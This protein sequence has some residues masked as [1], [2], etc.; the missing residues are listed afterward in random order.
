VA[1]AA[2]VTALIAGGGVANAAAAGRCGPHP[3]CATSLTPDARA[4]LL[5]RQLTRDEKITLLTGGAV[6]RLD[7]PPVKFT[8][9]GVGAGGLGAGFGRATAM[10]AG[11][12]LAAGFDSKMALAYGSLVGDEVKLRGFDGDYGPT[13]NIM[14]T[15]LGGRTFEAYGEDPFLASRMAVGWIQGAQ[16]Q[17]IIADVKH[18]AANNQEGQGGV[19]PGQGAVGGR[20]LINANVD[21]RTLREIYFPAFEAAIK[22]AHAGTVMCSYNRLNGT[23]ACEN[24]HLLL[25][26]LKHDWGFRGFVVSDAGAAHNT[27]ENLNN[28][29]DFDIASTGYSAPQVNLALATGQASEATLDGHVR[30]I[31]RTLFAFGFFDRPAYKDD[32]TRIDRKGHARL[33]QRV[34]E[35]AITLLQ[36]KAILPLDAR[37]LRSIA[38][39]GSAADRYVRGSG[40][41][42]VSTFYFVTAREGITRR[43]GPGVK[44]T[45]DDGSNPASA[46]SVARAADVAIVVAADSESEGTDKACMSLSCPSIGLPDIADG[47]NPQVSTGDTDLQISQVAAAQPKTIV[48]LETGAPVLTAWR[49]QVKGLLAAWYPGEE[50]GNAIARVL[51]GDVDPGGRLPATFPRQDADIPTAGDP[52]KYPGVADNETYKEGVLVGYRWYDANGI[53]PAFPFG[54]GL[55]YAKFAYRH[56]TVRAARPGVLGATIGVD[57]T[58]TGARAGTAVP[59]LYL[60]LPRPAPGVVQPPKQLKGFR[61][62]QLRRGERKHVSFNILAR[63][64]SY[65]DVKTRG[66]RVARGCYRVMLGSSSRAIVDTATLAVRGASC[67][68]AAA[69]TPAVRVKPKG[70]RGTSRCK[71]SSG[72]SGRGAG[73]GRGG[74]RKP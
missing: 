73:G 55:S 57:V 21:E 2:V 15:P 33:A 22:E 19:P 45:Y 43:A 6:Q 16:S 9:G 60:G 34:E 40:S 65:W 70:R 67:P 35:Q 18:Y 28:G 63:D 72:R 20:F 50:G 51:F 4:A 47:Q 7:V 42:E 29:L 74:C 62:L 41:S 48:V 71:G 69:R 11:I 66:W 3:W 53:A 37:R 64:L 46:A 36:N 12:A 17:G 52:E 26:V 68:G 10:P 31:L 39:I 59:Q 49:N 27:A 14:R 24:R 25:E 54:F 32:V 44:V 58:N 61:K 8:D 30:R 56:L 5:L 23:Y 13:V 1:V 38:I